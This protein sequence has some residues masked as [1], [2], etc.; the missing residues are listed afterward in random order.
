MDVKYL[1][2][3]STV[4]TIG[5][6]ETVYTVGESEGQVVVGVVVLA[7]ELSRDLVVSMET[8]DGSATSTG[9]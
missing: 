8:E 9:K 3:F 2:L 4:A 5:F 6:E 1:L 7:G